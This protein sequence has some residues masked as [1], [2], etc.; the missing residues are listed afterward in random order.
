MK[1]PVIGVLCCARMI[2]DDS[3]LHHIVFKSYLDFIKKKLNAVP[4]L[5]PAMSTCFDS[6]YAKNI[7]DRIDGVFLPGSPS[8]VSLR[9]DTKGINGFLEEDTNGI[10]DLARDYTAM[11]L[12]E[13]ALKVDKPILGVCRGFQEINVFFGGDLYKEL[14]KV[15]GRI[16]HRAKKSPSFYE[17][18]AP[19]HSISLCD[20]S[21]IKRLCS[22]SEVSDI[23][24]V[25]SLHTQGVSILGNGLNIECTASDGTVEAIR[26]PNASFVYGVQWHMEWLRSP[27]DEIIA[28]EFLRCC[29]N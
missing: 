10:N 23:C 11:S 26:Y 24:H 12:I 27:I 8:N 6:C 7:I 3:D 25:N 5:I 16:D 17:K 14:H 21:L 2:D 4:L 13:Y 18:Y 1:T 29:I 28:D 20:N 9:K 19:T 22:G 15:P